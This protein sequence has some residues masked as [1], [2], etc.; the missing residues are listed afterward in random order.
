MKPQISTATAVVISAFTCASF[1]LNPEACAKDGP[2]L[3]DSLCGG[4]MDDPVANPGGGPM[5]MKPDS[6][7]DGNSDP[8]APEYQQQGQAPFYLYRWDRRGNAFFHDVSSSCTIEAN[9]YAAWS[10]A[11]TSNASSNGSITNQWVPCL[12]CPDGE[13]NN[14]PFARRIELTPTGGMSLSIAMSIAAAPSNSVSATANGTGSTSSSHAQSIS[15]R[16]K[17]ITGSLTYSQGNIRA[18]GNFGAAVQISGSA[19]PRSI[20]G[21]GSIEGE[22]SD[23]VSWN[24]VGQGSAAGSL[25]IIVVAETKSLVSTEMVSRRWNNRA[26]TSAALTVAA[27]SNAATTASAECDIHT[28]FRSYSIAFGGR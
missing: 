14:E 2:I 12:A 18:E 25:N 19:T 26:S 28:S 17:S 15:V 24:L 21:G 3:D 23:E 4:W 13:V 5:C 22:Y 9:R 6:M 10:K 11:L 20:E 7:F 8:D 1:F 16:G 27:G